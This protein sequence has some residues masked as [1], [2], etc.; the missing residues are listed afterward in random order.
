MNDNFDG[1]DDTLDSRDITARIDELVAEWEEATGDNFEDY[2]LSED[3]LMVGLDAG[4]AGELYALIALR[5]EASYIFENDELFI[6]DEYFPEYAKEVLTSVG[7][8]SS[9]FPDWI[10]IDWEET[11]NNMLIDYTSYEF[12]GTTYWARA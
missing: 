9:E 11:A 4:D 2:S 7:Y 3:D 1:T 8:I 5:D 10:V 6:S 12:R